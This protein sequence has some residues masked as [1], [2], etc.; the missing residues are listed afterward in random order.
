L[1]RSNKGLIRRL[2]PDRDYDAFGLAKSDRISAA[3][4]QVGIGLLSI[5]EV[6]YIQKASLTPKKEKRTLS[7]LEKLLELLFHP[8]FKNSTETLQSPYNKTSRIN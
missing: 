1:G 6:I 7:I 2:L 5:R 8:H 4:K 3:R